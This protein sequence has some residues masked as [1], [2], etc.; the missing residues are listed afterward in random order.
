[1]LNDLNDTSQQIG[2]RMNMDKTKIMSNVHASPIPV[3]VENIVLETVYLDQL[4]V[5]LDI[6][7]PR[8][9]P[10]IGTKMDFFI[11]GGGKRLHEYIDLRHRQLG[12]IFYEKLGGNVPLIFISDPMMMRTFLN[13]EGKYPCHILPEPWVLYEKI[14][15]SKRGLFFMNGEEWAHN[16]RV[17]NKL[18]LKDGSE[19]WLQKPIN[20]TINNFIQL[21]KSKAGNNGFVPN[22]E[23]DFY[24]LST[25]V[26]IN[27]LLGSEGVSM[28][29]KHF[30]DLLKL[31]SE[32]VKMIFQ[33][34]TKLY[35]LPVYWCQSFN[36]KVWRDFKESVDLSIAIAQKIVHEIL[37]KHRE[38]NGLIK[39]LC[40]ENVPDEDIKRIVADFVIAAGDTTAYT[41][42][43]I[44]Y[45]LSKHEAVRNDLRNNDK[46]C[47]KNVIKESMRL[48]PV[49][50]F[51]TR[52]LPKESI[53]GSYT[54]SESTPIIASIYTSGRDEQNFSKANMFLPYRWD[55]NDI[56]KK[57]LVN[58]IPSASLPFALGARS[59]I[60]KKIAMIQLT[61]AIHQIVNN[62][63]FTCINSEDVKAVTSQVLVPDKDIKLVVSIL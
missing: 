53:L 31:F 41:S 26:I 57:E 19:K 10:I 34:T 28:G 62:F 47:T 43:W 44:L 20:D 42:L 48:F 22:L 39:R 37:N 59:C 56:R 40:D 29:S 5:R 32:T 54:L 6:P 13:L 61:E 9:L 4:V 24:R 16:R 55:R 63:D 17:M 33:T 27:V 58:H 1:M 8:T 46:N 18:I 45:L 3:I 36:L 11:A 15:G 51:L 23:T 7:S 60:G 2:L 52:I 21:W 14:H 49:A 12:P 35:G 25:Q 30:E 50:P 38:S